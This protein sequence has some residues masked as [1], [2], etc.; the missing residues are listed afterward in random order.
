MRRLA[1]EEAEVAGGIDDAGAEVM[2]PD[3]VCED[4]CGQRVSIAGDPLCERESALTLVCIRLQRVGLCDAV[5]NVEA[6]G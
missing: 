3:P 2:L 6:R 1:A 5:Q 4:P